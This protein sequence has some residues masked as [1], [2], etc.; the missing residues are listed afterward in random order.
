MEAPAPPDVPG[1][2][3]RLDASSVSSQMPRRWGEEASFRRLTALAVLKRGTGE[4]R[5]EAGDGL[6]EERRSLSRSGGVLGRAG[7]RLG[8]AIRSCSSEMAAG[9][10]CAETEGEAAAEEDEAAR[11]RRC[12]P[13]DRRYESS[14]SSLSSFTIEQIRARQ[15]PRRDEGAETGPEPDPASLSA[16]DAA[17]PPEQGERPSS[18]LKDD[19]VKF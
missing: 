8:P 18:M 13:G 15:E 17:P 9:R 2:C 4:A 3:S 19:S 6:R 12:E 10:L 5:P 14:S 1:R 11:V 7:R 16:S